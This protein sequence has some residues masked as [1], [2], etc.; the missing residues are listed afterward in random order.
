[1]KLPGGIWGGGGY[2]A[3]NFLWGE[4]GYFLGLHIVVFI[5]NWHQSI[6]K[7]IGLIKK[8]IGS[9]MLSWLSRNRSFI[10]LGFSPKSATVNLCVFGYRHW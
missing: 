4:Y 6:K 8:L 7:I 9:G 1:M 2:K 5:E 10:P 3:K